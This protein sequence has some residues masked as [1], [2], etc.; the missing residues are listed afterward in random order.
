MNRNIVRRT[1]VVFSVATLYLSLAAMA[2]A[3]APV[4]S[5]ALTAGK[6]GFSTTGTVVGIGPRSSLGIFT[7]DAAGNLLNGKATASLNGS[8][9]DEFFSGTYTVNPDCTGKFAIAVV[10][11]SGN[12]LFTATLSLVFDGN[13][14]Q[15][16]GM[17]TSVTLPNGTALGTVINADAK[18]LFPQSGDQQ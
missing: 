7:L 4:C 1:V 15:L 16:R 6:W 9:T 17:F 13:R 3:Q 8:V 12:K 11:S 14:R 5:L 10:D 2:Q 18:R